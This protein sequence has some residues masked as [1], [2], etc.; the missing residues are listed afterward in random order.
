V[1]KVV[2]NWNIINDRF[3]E[4]TDNKDRYIVCYGGRGSSKSDWA[5]KQQIL[6]LI[7]HN[8][9]RCIMI[10]KIQAKVKDSCYQNIKDLILELGLYDLFTFASTPVP[11]ITCKNGNFIVGAGM[12]NIHGVKSTKDPTSVWWEEDIPDESDF[13]TVTT[14]LRTMKADYIQE[15]FTINPEVE[16]DYR[17][18]WFFKKFLGDTYE[19]EGKRNFRKKT[20]VKIGEEVIEVPY[21]VH[22]ST[23]EDNP[24]LPQL[25][26]A[27]LEELRTSNPYYF[28]VYTLGEWGTKI[29]EGRFYQE[30]KQEKH[31][32]KDYEYNEDLPLH[33]SFDFN[34][35]PYT[36]VSIW[37]IVGKKFK[38][39][40][41]IAAKEPNNSTEGACNLFIEKYKRHE[42][43]LFVYGDPTGKNDDSKYEKGENHFHI[44]RKELKRFH[45]ETKLFQ[46]APSVTMRGNFINSIFKKNIY[47]IDIQI[48]EGCTNV[49]NDYLFGRQHSD[50]TKLKEKYKDKESGLTSEKYH[51]FSDGIDYLVCKVCFEDYSHFKRGGFEFDY[52]I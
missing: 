15:I 29:L 11:R 14:S 48:W 52:T 43:G 1:T 20:K 47:D 35:R 37:Q 38:C 31:T 18:N 44:I 27:M 45:P 46:K 42:S 21:T 22:H 19:I 12:D 39:I 7:N 51:H 4:L 17:E 49:I 26:R 32:Y 8:H 41:E 6:N 30:F 2:W 24:H 36:S 13:I 23:H 33:I 28:K 10:R 25:Y 3:R 40:D 5:A 34:V 16:G 50:G 9:Y